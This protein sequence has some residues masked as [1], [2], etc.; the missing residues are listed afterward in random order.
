MVNEEVNAVTLY[1]HYSVNKDK[2]PQRTLIT[3]WSP[4][5]AVEKKTELISAQFSL[6]RLRK[7]LTGLIVRCQYIPVSIRRNI[8]SKSRF[9]VTRNNRHYYPI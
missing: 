7:D 1:D 9:I 2:A 8:V 4:H 3:S 6:P 5:D